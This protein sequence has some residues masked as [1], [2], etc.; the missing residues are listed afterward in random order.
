LEFLEIHQRI[1]WKNLKVSWKNVQNLTISVW[2]KARWLK[3]CMWTCFAG[4]SMKLQTQLFDFFWNSL[5]SSSGNFWN[6]LEKLSKKSKSVCVE[7]EELK[8][9]MNMLYYECFKTWLSDFE[10][11][12][13]C[14]GFLEKIANLLVCNM[15][16]I[17]TRLTSASDFSI[18]EHCGVTNQ[19]KFKPKIIVL[20]NQFLWLTVFN[21]FL[22]LRKGHQ[23]CV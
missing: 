13:I 22:R 3:F 16:K 20:A 11:L 15:C 18:L 6:F 23:F 9:C 1:F 5:K 17:D 12:D 19:S 14:V 10:V 2:V 8:F 21:I 7:A 4:W